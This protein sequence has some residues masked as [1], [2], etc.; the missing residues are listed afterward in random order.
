MREGTKDWERECWHWVVTNK[1]LVELDRTNVVSARCPWTNT[2]SRTAPSCQQGLPCWNALVALSI[3]SPTEM[4]RTPFSAREQHIHC[5]IG[6]VGL[7]ASAVARRGIPRNWRRGRLRG[8]TS[9][10]SRLTFHCVI[11][12]PPKRSTQSPFGV[13]HSVLSYP[14]CPGA[15]VPGGAL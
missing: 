15:Q 13:G 3:N 12:R 1:G 9:E 11:V 10:T 7:L 2:F 5:H 6:G 8:R 4:S 14:W